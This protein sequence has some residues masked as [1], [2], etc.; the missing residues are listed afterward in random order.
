VTN[1]TSASL[2]AVLFGGLAAGTLDILFAITFWAVK[3]NVPASRI[4]QSVA[5]GLLGRDSFAGG[6]RTAAL[7]L[8]LHFLIAVSMSFAYYF[9]AKRWPA[10]YQRPWTC[11]AVYGLMLYLFMNF[12][13]VPLSAASPGSMDALWVTLSV[14]VHMLLIGVPI[15]LSVQRALVHYGPGNRNPR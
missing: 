8:I 14:V 15:A 13:V 7:G 11:G 6:W 3:A 9:L 2:L 10:L 4:L 1:R 12:V 5:A